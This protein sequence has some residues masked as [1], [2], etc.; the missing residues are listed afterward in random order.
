[1]LDSG[2]RHRAQLAWDANVTSDTDAQKVL[3]HNSRDE[4]PF[5]IFTRDP[6]QGSV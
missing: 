6:A 4:I 1:M 3:L 2:S 5:E